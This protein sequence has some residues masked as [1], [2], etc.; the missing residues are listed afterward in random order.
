MATVFCKKLAIARKKYNFARLGEGC[1]S[2]PLPQRLIRYVKTWIIH[3]V[4]S[5]LVSF[6]D[7]HARYIKY[8]Y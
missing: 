5:N 4:E 8:A 6:F 3:N 7:S 2:P 1:S